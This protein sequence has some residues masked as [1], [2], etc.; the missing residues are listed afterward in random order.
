LQTRNAGQIASGIAAP[1]AQEAD[2]L[3]SG[4]LIEQS[5]IWAII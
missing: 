3:F 5:L 4:S 1:V 2:D